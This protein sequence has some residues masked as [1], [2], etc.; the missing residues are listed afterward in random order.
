MVQPCDFHGHDLNGKSS[1]TALAANLKLA[2]GPNVLISE[3]RFHAEWSRLA[4]GVLKCS[5]STLKSRF[6]ELRRYKKLRLVNG[7]YRRNPQTVQ[8]KLIPTK[9]IEV[10]R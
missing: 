6:H 7:R 4:L 1:G 3:A 9:L 5:H 8:A 2:M 10:L